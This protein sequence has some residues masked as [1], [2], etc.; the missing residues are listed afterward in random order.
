MNRTHNNNELTIK[1]KG[2][3]VTL[4]GFVKNIRDHGGK[5]FIDLRDICGTTQ[6]VFDPKITSNFSQIEDIKKEFVIKISGEVVKRP[7]DQENSKLKTGEIEVNAFEYEIFSQ[8]KML[9]FGIDDDKDELSNED[10]RLE[11]RYLDLRR[12]SMS[13]TFIRR[14][15]FLKSIRDIFE[16]NDFID[17]ETPILTTSSPEGARDFLVPS[18]KHKGS[19]F[20]LPQAPQIFKQL[21]MVSGF[22]KYFQITKCFRDEDL[23]ADRQYEFTQIDCEV[24]Y[25]SQEE[26]FKFITNLIKKSFKKV[27]D[28][29]IEN[30][31]LVL[32]YKKC[33][34]DFGCDKPDLR[35][36]LPTLKDFTKEFEKC[37][38][39][40]F[41]NNI[42]NGGIVKALNFKSGANHLSRG[43]IDK[44][45][46]L[47]QSDFGAKGLAWFKTNDNSLESSIAKFFND[48][49]LKLIKEKLEAENNDLLFFISD[50]KENTNSILDKLRRHL[51]YTFN[52]FEKNKYKL[53]FVNNFPLFSLDE[54]TKKLDFEHNPFTMCH[55]KDISQILN[56]D[57]DKKEDVEKLLNLTS[58]CY[59]LVFNGYEILSGAQR[60]TNPKV[61]R[62]MFELVSFD[63]KKVE[64]SFGWFLKAYEYG[65][66]PHRGF[67][68]GVD[69]IIMILENKSSI[70]DVIPFP[71]NKHGFCPLTKSPKK[72]E[73]NQLKEVGIKL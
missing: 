47:S 43:E 66:P 14:S 65:S 69:R 40:V 31:I 53:C 57:K 68:L 55:Q 3:K 23:R 1:D 27:Y 38:F 18:R 5:K 4:F 36:N 21:L 56:S 34:D 15:K 62:K 37:N 39:S 50:T 30:D 70:R 61:Q 71:R 7:E 28:I 8:S 9:P 51:A 13:K 72:V 48:N 12:E 60:I 6:I 42:K 52:Y 33:L 41:S 2:K 54:E 17:I 16:E 58:D 20:A 26:I 49:E 63:E 22:E 35:I 44:L 59:D 32:D 25:I 24:S 67:A 45:I 10:L 11:Y 46:K 73:S 64:D 19:F 29:D